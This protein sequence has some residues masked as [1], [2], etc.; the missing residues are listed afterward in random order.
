MDDNERTH[1]QVIYIQQLL[2]L[3]VMNI[4]FVMYN[5]EGLRIASI[6]LHALNKN[7]Q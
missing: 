4:T 7:D 3:D 6:T 2:I 1:F 5:T